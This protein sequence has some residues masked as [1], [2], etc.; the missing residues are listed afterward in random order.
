MSA[1]AWSVALAL[2]L[3]AGEPPRAAHPVV[4][5]GR[6]VS[7][8]ERFAPR[9]AAAQRAFGVALV[10]VPAALAALSGVGVERMRARTPRALAS[11]WLLKS[12]FALRDLVTAAGRVERALR[13][14]DLADARRELGALVSRETGELRADEVASAAVESLAENL[15]DSF[16]APLLAYRVGGLPAVLAYRAVNTAD[17]MVGYRGRYEHLGKAAARLDDVLNYVPARLSA[18]AIVAAAALSSGKAGRHAMTVTLRDHARTASPNAG[19]P[20]SA[21]AGALGLRLAKPGQYSLGGEGRSPSADDVRR[22]GELTLVAAALATI[23]VLATYRGG[24]R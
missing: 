15:C 12:A 2:D 24:A 3:V 8:L 18:L 14:R 9:D 21:A 10:G 7:A 1:G 22:A 20:M 5:I 13:R 17:A 23:A 16:V 19:W 4:L 6:A 11:I